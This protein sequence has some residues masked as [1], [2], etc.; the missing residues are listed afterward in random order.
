MKDCQKFEN[1][2]QS[3]IVGNPQF[4]Q[5][6]ELVEHC[7]TCQECRDLFEMHRTL[8]DL[9]S[10]FD[11]LEAVDLEDAR[12]SI[13]EQVAA[14]NRNRSGSKWKAVIQSPFTLRPLAATV[15]LVFVFALGL[16]ASL[17]VGHAPSAP[18]TDEAII[19]AILKN[20]ANSPYSFSNVAVRYVDDNRVSLIVDVTK[21]V[22]IVEPAHSELVKGVLMNSQFNPSITGAVGNFPNKPPRQNLVW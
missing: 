17:L 10:R 13:V 6:E 5:L 16:V 15:L 9:G 21:R 8:A 4:K 7:K 14:R 3:L 1:A 11:E 19:R 20:M 22:T 18:M 12:K 2:I